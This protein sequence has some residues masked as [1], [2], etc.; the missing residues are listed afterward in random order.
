MELLLF[1]EMILTLLASCLAAAA[2][3]SAFLVGRSKMML[4]SFTGFL[5]YFFDVVLVFQDV[6]MEH[7]DAAFVHDGT[8]LLVRSFLVIFTGAGFLVS[9]WLIICEYVGDTRE[10]MRIVPGLVFIGLSEFVLV[11]FPDSGFQ[12]FAFYTLRS[13]FLLWMLC[14]ATMRFLRTKDEF[15]RARL[16]RKRWIAATLV[17]LGA[18]IVIEDVYGFLICDTPYFQIGPVLIS[19]ERNY[20]ENVLLLACAFF[21]CRDA[22]RMLLMR[23]HEPTAIKDGPDDEKMRENLLAYARRYG[24]SAR[25]REVLGQA[26]S[27]KDNQN[28]ASGMGIA[29]NTVKVHM[30]N[31]FKKTGCANRKELS[32]DFWKRM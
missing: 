23:F 9:L 6:F 10:A 30:H 3:L 7:I 22:A 31:I 28:I 21:A 4:Y 24:L 26:L 14:A 20:A 19:S 11:G 32:Q 5:S 12:R 17:V 8:Y 15:E 13:V 18:C 16:W 25:E 2:C 27:G 29:L 1:Y